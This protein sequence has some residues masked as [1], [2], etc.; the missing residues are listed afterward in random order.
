MDFLKRFSRDESGATAVEYG[1]IAGAMA[2]VVI[3]LWTTFGPAVRR[4]YED[5]AAAI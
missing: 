3:G 5:V 1:M 2:L 4:L